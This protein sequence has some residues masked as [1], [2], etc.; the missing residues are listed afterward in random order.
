MGLDITGL[1]AA[2][3]FGSKIIEKIWPNPADREKAKIE[4]FK[5]QQQG[6]FK[7]LD[8]MLE[9]GRQQAEINKV[10]AANASVFVAGWRPFI[11]WIC[12]TA[13]AAHFIAVP[14]FAWLARIKGW[15]EPP[16]LDLGDL[17]MLLGGMLG[18]GGLRSFD[19]LKGLSR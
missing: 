3:D 10:E 9:A 15:P 16:E 17:F 13:L 1:G 18:F 12:G 4:L 2:F 6:E 7:Q 19:K 14:T 5:L 8:A 11:G